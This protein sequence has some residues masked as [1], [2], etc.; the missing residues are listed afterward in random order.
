MYDCI[1]SAIDRNEYAIGVFIH[2]A[3]AFDTLNHDILLQKLECYGI[4]GMPLK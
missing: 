1:S 3:K 4:R 2:L